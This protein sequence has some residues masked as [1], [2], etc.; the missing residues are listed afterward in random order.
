MFTLSEI[1]GLEV[2]VPQGAMYSMSTP[3]LT[4]ENLNGLL[5]SVA[6]R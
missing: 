2:V 1:S 4:I 6:C 5:I 3:K